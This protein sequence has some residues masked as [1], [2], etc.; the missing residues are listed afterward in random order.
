MTYKDCLVVIP[1]F[2]EA[3]NIESLIHAILEN[4]PRVHVLII[5]DGSPDGT[6][7]IC[8]RISALNANV[9]IFSRKLKLGLASAFVYGLERGLA[10][11]YKNVVL[12]DGDGSHRV[13]DLVELLIKSNHDIEAQ[14]VLGSR[15]IKGGRVIN[16]PWHRILLSHFGNTYAR[17]A[18][19]IKVYDVT[20]GFRVF[21]RELIEKIDFEKIESEGFC[22]HIEM[23]KIVSELKQ[24]IVEVPI[25]F[26]EREFGKSK[27]NFA[28]AF[29]SLQNVTIWGL[30][31]RFP[32]LGQ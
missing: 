11:G 15:W 24:N 28:I 4:L 12:M 25:I 22:F 9:L 5:D 30:K 31:K 17:W 2:N 3:E 8:Q 10:E 18:L 27:M 26:V 7:A 29:E 14:L 19:G 16:W 21:R 23:T 32:F 13:L 6:L 1:T 20:S